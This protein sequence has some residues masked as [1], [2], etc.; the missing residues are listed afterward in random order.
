MEVDLKTILD[1][2]IVPFF[3]WCIYVDRKIVRLESEKITKKDLENIYNKLDELKGNFVHQSICDV[4][5]K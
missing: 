1:Y 5:H 3:I 4:K 2:L